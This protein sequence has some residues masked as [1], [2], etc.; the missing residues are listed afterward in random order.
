MDLFLHRNS[1]KETKEKYNKL[2]KKLYKVLTILALAAL[3]ITTILLVL[4]ISNDWPIEVV[5]APLVVII[6]FGTAITAIWYTYKKDSFFY[7]EFT[8]LLIKIIRLETNYDIQK[9]NDKL[10]C[11][12]KVLETKFANNGEVINVKS[13]LDFEKDGITGSLMMV[14]TTTAGEHQMDIITGFIV[15]LN[16][17]TFLEM[18]IRTDHNRYSKYRKSKLNKSNDYTV[19]YPKNKDDTAIPDYVSKNLE[20]IN[21][22]FDGKFF[23]IDYQNDKVSFF[24]SE[25]KMEKLPKKFEEENIEKICNKYIHYLEKSKEFATIIIEEF[26]W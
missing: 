9:N 8:E 25:E 19:Y 18:Q 7:N 3:F 26:K 20:W 12:E 13:S 21:T 5:L 24:V 14:H 23:G 2:S 15:S 1:I 4:K 16:L 6:V 22:N 17:P 10:V 11:H